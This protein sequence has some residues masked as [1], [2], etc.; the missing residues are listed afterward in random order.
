MHA[1]CPTHLILLEVVILYLYLKTST[2][3]EDPNI[4]SLSTPCSQTLSVDVLRLKA[5]TTFRTH[6]KLQTKL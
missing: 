3:Y 6:I 5:E 1:T 4:L 2:S